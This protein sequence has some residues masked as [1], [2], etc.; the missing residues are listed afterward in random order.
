MVIKVRNGRGR[1]LS[2]YK[3]L[4]GNDNLD[5]VGWSTNLSKFVVEG[6]EI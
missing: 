5:R 4:E 3:D 1:G 2:Y 6:A